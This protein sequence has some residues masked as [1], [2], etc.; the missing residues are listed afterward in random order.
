ML[1]AALLD[2]GAGSIAQ[3]RQK[4]SLMGLEGWD[5]G[6]EKTS[7]N[8]IAAS[9]FLV[10][11]DERGHKHRSLADIEKIIS[12]ADLGERVK[13]RA[14][15]T[16]ARLAAAE[17]AAH[18]EAADEVLFH[19]VG[20]TDSIID[21]VSACILLE[22]VDPDDVVSSTV[23]LGSGVVQTRHGIMP[24]P[25]PATLNL[26]KDVPV[27]QGNE[28]MELTTPTGA[29][30]LREFASRFGPLPPLKASAVGYGAGT[31]KTEQ[32]PNL[33]RIIYGEAASEANKPAGGRPLE[34]QL[35]LESNIDDS[36]PEQLAFLVERLMAAGATDTWM[37]PV[38]MKKGRPGV[39]LSVLCPDGLLDRLAD[40]VFMESTT[41]GMRLS[42][43][44]RLCLD[45]RVEEVRT[46]YGEISVK[47]G[48]WKG[49]AVS[50]SPEYEDCRR[51]ALEHGAPIAEVFGAAKSAA[52]LII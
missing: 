1:V 12:G 18:G 15:A 11:V 19:E 22:A 31:R 6:V 50:I 35:L 21:V 26:L 29:A 23:M 28:P 7:V 45:R 33:L 4:L 43:V 42:R 20:M 51:A 25:A 32:R 44:E 13:A 14:L 34:E 40:I 49:R 48:I 3:L 17:A 10:E 47:I 27:M 37:D 8:G 16:F 52:E 9:R 24:V 36:T 5:I 39:V 41:F 46:P 2:M 38:I 30:L